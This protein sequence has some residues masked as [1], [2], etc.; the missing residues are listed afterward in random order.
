[1]NHYRGNW[2]NWGMFRT[3]LMQQLFSIFDTPAQ[4]LKKHRFLSLIILL[5]NMYVCFL[6]KLKRKSY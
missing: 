5:A 6:S 3:V 4:L 2:E 1:M